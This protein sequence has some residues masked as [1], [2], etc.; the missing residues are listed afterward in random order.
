MKRVLAGDQW[1]PR[2]SSGR[3]HFVRAIPNLL[4]HRIGNFVKR[5]NR[6]LHKKEWLNFLSVRPKVDSFPKP[7]TCQHRDISWGLEPIRRI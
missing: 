1:W 7:S 3:L 5:N 2:T 4:R 6:N